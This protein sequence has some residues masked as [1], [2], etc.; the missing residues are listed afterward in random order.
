MN[1]DAELVRYQ[2]VLRRAWALEPGD[3][4]LD[5]GCG[6]G[7]TTHAAALVTGS[8]V[9]IDVSVA[10]APD[11]PGVRFLRGDAQTYEFVP[12]SFDVAVSRFGTMFFDD[13]VAAFANIGRA[14][15]PG[16]RLVMVVWQSGDRNEWDV[17]IRGALGDVPVDGPDPFALADP[18][19]VE[20]ILGAA[21]FLDIALTDVREPVRYGPDVDAAL[22]WVRGFTCTN[23]LLERLDPVAGAHALSRLRDALAARTAGDGVWFDSRAWLVT[24]RSS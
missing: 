11:G 4:V 14:L 10:R 20:S 5:I 12:G 2:E 7:G 24:G 22:A 18:A 1:Y 16:G 19:T 15:K 8:A 21:G 13:P 9:G 17:V 23:S 6:A 3:R